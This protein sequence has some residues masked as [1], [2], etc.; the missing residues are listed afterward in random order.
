ML[1]F[2]RT[3]GFPATPQRWIALTQHIQRCERMQQ[4]IQIHRLGSLPTSEAPQHLPN[5]DVDPHH[6]SPLLLFSHVCANCC[7]HIN[8]TVEVFRLSETL[9]LTIAWSKAA[10]IAKMHKVDP[11][12]ELRDEGHRIKIISGTQ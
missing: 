5:R 12:A 11:V 10:S 2:K 9:R 4:E 1:R 6:G 3:T 8:V 7:D